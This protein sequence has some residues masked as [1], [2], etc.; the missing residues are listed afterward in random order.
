MLVL[1][2]VFGLVEGKKTKIRSRLRE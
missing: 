2:D 1:H